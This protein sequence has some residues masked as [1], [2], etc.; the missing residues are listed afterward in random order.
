MRYFKI[1]LSLMIV[2]VIVYFAS[3]FF[4]INQ[5]DTSFSLVDLNDIDNQNGFLWDEAYVDTSWFVISDIYVKNEKSSKEYVEI[6]VL[7]Y[8]SD[9]NL[10]NPKN[11]NLFIEQI[12][13][14]QIEKNK[15]TL[16]CSDIKSLTSGDLKIGISAEGKEDGTYRYSFDINIHGFDTKKFDESVIVQLD[17]NNQSSGLYITLI[18]LLIVAFTCL[19]CW[20][21]LL[22]KEYYPT[23]SQK[24]RLII[25]EPDAST[26][27]FTKKAR[28]LIIGNKLKEKENFF[29]KLFIG[30]IQHE[31]QGSSHSALITPYKDW[32]TQKV[33]Y[34]LSCNGDT[35]S[36][37]IN[38][39]SYLKHHDKYTLRTD[40][41]KISFEYFNI[42]HQ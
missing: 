15:F 23:F 29:T 39:V 42:K 26:I 32:K 13:D 37:I 6:S 34:R 5:K 17:V 9:N 14:S 30:E 31:F 21:L 28:K 41:E 10:V 33:L 38:S 36:E 2:G 24:G 27:F 16:Y 19:L 7:E 40:D 35:N 25:S 22:K 12:S 11:I 18:I 20:F 4:I 1:I 3:T 8:N